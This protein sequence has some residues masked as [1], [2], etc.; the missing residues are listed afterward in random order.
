MN[1]NEQDLLDILYICLAAY[2]TFRVYK[3]LVL[4]DCYLSN[5]PPY[6]LSTLQTTHLTQS[7]AS[8][9]SFAFI[10]FDGFFCLQFAAR[11]LS[12]NCFFLPQIV[13]RVIFGHN[14]NDITIFS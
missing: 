7:T 14:N 6:D 3:D 11:F 10:F 4:R 5:L 1:T 13:K 12:Q 8:N 2:F 9:C